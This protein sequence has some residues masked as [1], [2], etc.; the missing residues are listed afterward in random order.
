ML[1]NTEIREKGMLINEHRSRKDN[2]VASV[3][4]VLDE[5]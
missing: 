1:A 4:V 2:F 3:K 5:T